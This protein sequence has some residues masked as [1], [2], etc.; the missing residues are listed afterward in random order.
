M[1]CPT[2]AFSGATTVSPVG[3]CP[4][5]GRGA[6]GFSGVVVSV[7]FILRAKMQKEIPSTI[8]EIPKKMAMRIARS[9]GEKNIKRERRIKS[10]PNPASARR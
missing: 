2:P 6:S 4:N 8:T 9:L 3:D 10:T 1:L 5:T 7:V